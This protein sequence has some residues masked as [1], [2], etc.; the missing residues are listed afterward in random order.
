M[1][2]GLLWPKSVV[3]SSAG[4]WCSSIPV[5]SPPPSVA[6]RP[7]VAAR[8][9]MSGASLR[10]RRRPRTDAKCSSILAGSAA[11]ASN[12]P[13]RH[14]PAYP[15]RQAVGHRRPCSPLV[16]SFRPRALRCGMLA[17]ATVREA[18][19]TDNAFSHQRAVATFRCDGPSRHGAFA[20]ARRIVAGDGRRPSG[21][22]R[23]SSIPLGSQVRQPVPRVPPLDAFQRRAADHRRA[24]ASLLAVVRR[25]QNTLLD[26]GCSVFAY[27]LAAEWPPTR[28]VSRR[29][30][31]FARLEREL[32]TPSSH[33]A[34][35][36]P[37]S[38]AMRPRD[39]APMSGASLPAKQGRGRT[40][41]DHPV[42]SAVRRRRLPQTW[43]ADCAHT[44]KTLSE[45]ITACSRS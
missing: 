40:R 5:R 34:C 18:G 12:A 37:P 13:T 2:P 24:C 7:R 8:S 42:P 30:I 17:V 43:N 45:T 39:A 9:P 15:P 26:S 16:A 22:A 25:G 20:D 11:L 27:A 32:I 21:D 1:G 14:R 41:N 10:R 35:S 23:R 4:D 6:P 33:P 36:S 28:Q 38:V 29:S 31:R 19:A 44:R 3:R